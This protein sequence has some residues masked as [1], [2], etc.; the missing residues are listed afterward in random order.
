MSVNRI[1]TRYAKSLLELAV[2]RNSL[3]TIKG[4]LEQLK[5]AFKNKITD[6]WIK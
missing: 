6:W 2:E 3:E 1:A 4:D 5:I